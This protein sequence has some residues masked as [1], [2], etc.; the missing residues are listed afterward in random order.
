MLDV[1]N[2]HITS[3][4]MKQIEFILK[5]LFS[6]PVYLARTPSRETLERTSDDRRRTTSM[7]SDRLKSYVNTRT[8]YPTSTRQNAW[9]EPS[10]WN[11]NAFGAFDVLN[12]KTG[13]LH[14]TDDIPQNFHP[15]NVPTSNTGPPRLNVPDLTIGNVIPDNLNFDP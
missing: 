8:Q 11:D 1:H 2:P 9:D 6:P 3:F 12:S 10:Y 7:E 13:H 5:Q 14:T 15:P 4:N